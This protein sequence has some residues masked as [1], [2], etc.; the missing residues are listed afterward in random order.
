MVCWPLKAINNCLHKYYFYHQ[1]ST[2]HFSKVTHP[3]VEILLRLFSWISTKCHLQ[4]ETSEFW[5]TFTFFPSSSAWAGNDSFWRSSVVTGQGASHLSHL[6]HNWGISQNMTL[7]TSLILE[8]KGVLMVVAQPSTAA[9]CGFFL[10]DGDDT[11][12]LWGT[13]APQL[14]ADDDHSLLWKDAVNQTD[15]QENVSLHNLVD[16]LLLNINIIQKEWERKTPASVLSCAILV[17]SD[18]ASST[19][20]KLW[21]KYSSYTFWNWSFGE[22]SQVKPVI[23]RVTALK[24]FILYCLLI[25]SY[26]NRLGNDNRL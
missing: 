12:L 2:L 13:T 22:K 15:F 25:K 26:R 4:L 1:N 24:L 6:F 5:I 9:V 21:E 11:C 17:L 8:K 23:L 10:C 16:K 20:A 14:L 19:P 3:I 7:K 18:I